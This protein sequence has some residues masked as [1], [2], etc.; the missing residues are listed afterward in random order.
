MTPHVGH[1]GASAGQSPAGPQAPLGMPGWRPAHGVPVSHRPPSRQHQE[2]HPEGPV[3]PFCP[4]PLSPVPSP[5]ET[6]IQAAFSLGPPCCSHWVLKSP[7]PSTEDSAT[8]GSQGPPAHNRTPKSPSPHVEQG[9]GA[10]PSLGPSTSLHPPT[11]HLRASLQRAWS[12][13]LR[14]L[15]SWVKAHPAQ[16]PTGQHRSWGQSQPGSRHPVPAQLPGLSTTCPRQEADKLQGSKPPPA[17]PSCPTP[18]LHTPPL[19]SL[20]S[21]HSGLGGFQVLYLKAGVS[22]HGFP[23][24]FSP[25]VNSIFLPSLPAPQYCTRSLPHSSAQGT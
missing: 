20:P 10:L 22:L 4:S 8:R 6:V 3:Y 2:D 23:C 1:P 17:F 21:L 9:R 15:P 7:C 24:S 11:C 18:L 12:P 16:V 13:Q 25:L 5:V 14:G 19:P